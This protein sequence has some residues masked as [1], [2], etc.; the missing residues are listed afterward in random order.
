MSQLKHI[1]ILVITLF[2]FGQAAESQSTAVRPYEGAM[3]VYTCNGI[4]AGADYNFYITA[5]ADGS[6]RFDDG[7]TGEFDIINEKGKVGEDGLASSPIQWNMGAS[8]RIYYLWLEATAPGGC[9]NYISM[10]IAPQ[11]NVF[12]ILSENIP[13]D[14]TVSCPA[15]ASTDGFNAIASTYDAGSTTL[16]FKIRRENGTTNNWSFE[17]VLTVDPAYNLGISIVSIV[18]VNS[19][20][21]TADTNKLYTVNGTDSEVI[22][23]VA[24]KNLPGTIQEVSLMIK[25]QGENNTNL[26]DS[27]PANDTVRHRIEIMPVINGLQG[28]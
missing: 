12:D 18:G 19:G 21:L 16:N 4:S 10:Q 5:N 7:L 20:N 28:V 11:L 23:T 3:H 17:P 25:N 9:S 22:V 14:N 26:Q 2:A 13:V 27:N 24:V 15:I 8:M 1:I 6:G